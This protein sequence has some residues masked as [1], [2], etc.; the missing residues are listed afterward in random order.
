MEEIGLYKGVKG[1]KTPSGDSRPLL[2]MKL[3]H[4]QSQSHQ[5]EGDSHPLG[6]LGQLG[7]QALSLILGQEGVSSAGD[8]TGQAGALAGLEHNN[9]HHSQRQENLNNS[10]SH[11]HKNHISF[12]SPMG[13]KS[14]FCPGQPD[15]Q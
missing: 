2:K 12:Q 9:G 13:E 7:V 4:A 3:D 14:Y 5:N 10:E 15:A 1:R 11:L 6:H 8:G